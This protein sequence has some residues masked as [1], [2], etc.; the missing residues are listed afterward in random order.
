MTKQTPIGTQV[1]LVLV[2]LYALRVQI[3]GLLFLW[4]L[5]GMACRS[6]LLRG[7]YDIDN[8]QV[9]LVSQLAA[10]QA[11]FLA[12]TAN[13]ILLWSR[14]RL[15]GDRG[16]VLY[17]QG[18]LL[19]L[20][21]FVSVVSLTFWLAFMTDVRTGSQASHFWLAS[22]SGL[23]LILL[24]MVMFE[25]ILA[26]LSPRTINMRLFLVPL[27]FLWNDTFH[28]ASMLK[29]VFRQTLKIPRKIWRIR[30]TVIRSADWV[31]GPG[32][33]NYRGIRPRGML[34]GH[35]AALAVF[36]LMLFNL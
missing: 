28:V 35:L 3:I 15:D 13:L 4:P 36:L 11:V 21:R 26:F 8:K 32:F 22:L 9:A 1:R 14:I 24:C 31:L 7:L 2:H 12:I 16:P 17:Q 27:P 6:P 19:Q 23:I 20:R 18:H 34:P 30:C 33:M 5:A 10:F 25:E 29:N